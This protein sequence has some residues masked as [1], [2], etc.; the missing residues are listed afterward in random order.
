MKAGRIKEERK[1]EEYGGEMEGATMA[2]RNGMG[3]DGARDGA[4]RQLSKH[5]AYNGMSHDMHNRVW[6]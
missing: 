5:P 1:R 3:G 2:G 6:A 4:C